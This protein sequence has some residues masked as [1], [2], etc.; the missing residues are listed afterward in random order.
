MHLQIEHRSIAPDNG[1]GTDSHHLG[2]RERG[3][4]APERQAAATGWMGLTVV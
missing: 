3:R 4:G 2:P 1:G